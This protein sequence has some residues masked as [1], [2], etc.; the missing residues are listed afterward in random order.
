M[1]MKLVSPGNG[2]VVLVT[3]KS[4]S[5]CKPLLSEQLVAIKAMSP[6]QCACKMLK[7]RRTGTTPIVSIASDGL[8]TEPSLT[9]RGSGGIVS[10]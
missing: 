10:D 9:K 8:H 3:E 1:A 7:F 6:S 4:G 2:N 5:L